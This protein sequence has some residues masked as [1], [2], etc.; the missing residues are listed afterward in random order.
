MLVRRVDANNVGYFD[1][2]R[3]ERMNSA[4]RRSRHLWASH[5]A[6]SCSA[7]VRARRHLTP[8]DSSRNVRDNGLLKRRSS[9]GGLPSG[10]NVT[11]VLMA[12]C[13][14]RARHIRDRGLSG[15]FLD[16]IRLILTPMAGCHAKEALDID[17]GSTSSGRILQWLRAP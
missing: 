9:R 12:Q 13:Q 5:R 6:A 17:P 2:V 16:V 11:F 8:S 4:G 10:T 1:L 3:V 15:L 7:R 14:R